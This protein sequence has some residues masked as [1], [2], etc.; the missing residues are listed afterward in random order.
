MVA[1][2]LQSLTSPLSEQLGDLAASLQQSIVAVRDGR[3]G[4]GTGVVW[5]PDMIITNH[6][7]V[8]GDQ[9]DLVFSD[10]RQATGQVIG[11]DPHNDIVALRVEGTPEP[12]II[13]DSTTVRVG[14]IVVA[15]GH[16]MG[17]EH[18]V[19][20]GIVSG[21]PSPSDPRALIRSD[22]H[23]LPGNSGGP[24]LTASGS[25]I[26]INA[27]VAGPGTALSVPE[28]TIRAFLAR[29]AG[30]SPVLG[31]ELTPVA[32]PL[33]WRGLALD[34]VE[35]ALLVTGVEQGSVA[36]LAGIYPGDL[37]LGVGD[38]AVQHP[39]RL[40]EELSTA[41]RHDPLRLRLIRGGRP[42]EIDI[43]QAA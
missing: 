26:G 41:A 18:A 19:T 31:L 30:Q 8:G 32:L 4:S 37:L 11:R 23:L 29:I 10:G 14:Q 15:I 27:M 43:S 34:N 16:P 39:L 20:V 2:P 35:H 6:H 21:L 9:A 13:G 3:R 25:V 7:V 12:A 38:R 40:R 1:T 33:A 22:L 42:L 17:I 36:E 24:L 5:S 28:Y